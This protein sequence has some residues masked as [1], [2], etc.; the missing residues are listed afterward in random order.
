MADASTCISR[1]QT[2]TAATRQKFSGV[3]V[4]IAVLVSCPVPGLSEQAQK[5]SEDRAPLPAES[6]TAKTKAAERDL[7][8]LV[9]EEFTNALGMQ[10]RLIP[11]GEFTM[12]SDRGDDDEKPPRKIRIQRP[13]YMAKYEVTQAEWTALMG[14][15]PWKDQGFSTKH[16][17]SPAIYVNWADAQEFVRR[18]NAREA[19]I[20]YSLPTERQWE[21]AARAGTTSRY[22]F[23]DDPAK[24]NDYG[25]FA[26]NTVNARKAL[27][28]GQ[29]RANP[30][31]LYDIH[32]NVWEW[33]L[34]W[35]D[36]DI[37]PR[38]RGG[39]WAS[40]AESLR[41]ANRSAAPAER[42]AGHIGFRLVRSVEH[43]PGLPNA[44]TISERSVDS[45]SALP[46][47]AL[48]QSQQ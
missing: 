36:E 19:C 34:D 4:A 12:G 26:G 44:P 7:L 1:P 39:S 41:S 45:G 46:A 25:W 18:L 37:G 42:R 20:C 8:T 14:T 13:F 32:G 43:S 29:K 47:G 27:P 23:G 15:E 40:P 33:V 16:E 11:A 30:W 22:S 31:G 48:K 17:R 9:P 6:T 2:T 21:R 35:R 38:I 3:L 5:R 28:V 10:F 24:L